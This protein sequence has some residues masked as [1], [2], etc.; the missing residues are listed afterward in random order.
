MRP[1]TFGLTVCFE[2]YTNLKKSLDYHR[3]TGIATESAIQ[4]SQCTL[5][6]LK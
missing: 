1:G 3:S 6:V 2:D 5:E 4:T